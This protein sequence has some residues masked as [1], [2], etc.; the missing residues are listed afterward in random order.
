MSLDSIF[1]SLCSGGNFKR[2][3]HAPVAA[4]ERPGK[5]ARSSLPSSSLDFF[6]DTDTKKRTGEVAIDGHS[7]QKKSKKCPPVGQSGGPAAEVA[8]PPPS[9]K[10]VQAAAEEVAAFRRRL[11]IRIVGGRCPAPVANFDDLPFICTAS[12]TKLAVLRAIEESTWKEPSPVQMQAISVLCEGRDLVAS[13]P[14]GSGK[15]AAFVL[16]ALIVLSRGKPALPNSPRALLMAPTR[17]LAAQIF[18]EAS[19]LSAGTSI[20]VH[21]LTKAR[22]ATAKQGSSNFSGLLVTTPGR[23]VAVVRSGAGINLSGVELVVLDEV[24]RVPPSRMQRWYVRSRNSPLLPRLIDSSNS[25]IRTTTLTTRQDSL[26]KST[27]YVAA[28]ASVKLFIS[29]VA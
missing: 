13:A 15:T 2:K 10:S 18:R 25:V 6:S 14:T 7:K 11:G 23:L 1:S 5:P 9:S 28:A 26:D 17:E 19:A 4:K 8:P 24:P 29:R 22:A 20:P 21:L 27:R 3:P 16:P 12:R